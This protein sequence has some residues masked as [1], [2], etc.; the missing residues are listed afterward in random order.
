MAKRYHRGNQKPLEEE[1]TIHW[2]KDTTEVIRSRE[3]EDNTMA[4]KCGI[5]YPL[6]CLFFL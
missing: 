6:Y 2:L 1:Q 3:E 5:F 4:K